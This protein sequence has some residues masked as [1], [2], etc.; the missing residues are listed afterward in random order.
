MNIQQANF[1]KDLRTQKVP[2]N[3]IAKLFYQKFGET[4]FCCGPQVSSYKGKKIFSFSGIDGNDIVSAASSFL[5]Q[6]L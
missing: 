6:K 1:V 3:E 4:Q 5:R 2:L